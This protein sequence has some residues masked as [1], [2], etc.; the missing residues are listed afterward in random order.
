[1]L[2]LI[3]FLLILA[4]AGLIPWIARRR[5]QFVVHTAVSLSG[6]S[7]LIW[8]VTRTQLPITMSLNNWV[9]SG[10]LAN[11]EWQV[12]TLNWQVTFAILL[13]LMA[14][15]LSKLDV[16]L[17]E[18]RPLPYLFLQT[19][20]SLLAIW[21]N[22][23]PTMIVG[24]TLLMLPWLVAVW[25]QA[26]GD[27]TRLLRYMAMIITALVFLWYAVAISPIS[28]NWQ[29]QAFATG[30]IAAVVIAAAILVGIWPFYVWRLRLTAV[31]NSTAIMTFVLP[32]AIGG[33]I[34]ARL[35]EAT[36]PGINLQLLVTLLALFGILQSMRLAW[37]HLQSPRH[38][39]L[40]VLFAQ[41][42]LVILT[43]IWANGAAVVA[44]LRV[45]ILVGGILFLAAEERPSR[46]RFWTFLAPIVAIASLAALPLTA[47]FV[48]RAALYSAWIENGRFLLAIILAFLTV[49]LI[50]AVYIR[51]W[52]P[53]SPQI[54]PLEGEEADNGLP[55]SSLLTLNEI[56]RD[57]GVVLLA[58]GLFT[59]LGIGWGAVHW[60]AWILILLTLIA[61]LI[62]PRF[63]G[64]A[65][66]IQSLFQQAFSFGDRLPSEQVNG[67]ARDV[68]TA[69][70][71]AARILEGEGGLVWL[72]ILAVLFFLLS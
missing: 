44:E 70:R 55:P 8:I 26:E 11:V 7:L 14:I 3:P 53:P 31:P 12:D 48:G 51:F 6:I 30:G 68:G 38:I 62:L 37:A 21:S 23:L 46:E 15:C 27:N 40:A 61:G 45:L 58:F 54:S 63:M 49:P 67:L 71:D 43:G 42:Q 47:G 29:V 25:Q 9:D 18:L 52:Q 5:A 2:A 19:A 41:A 34:F 35:A 1:M 60:L 28:D 56:G 13:L 33:I 17:A 10:F 64:E 36:Q 39:A 4:G 65:Q 57:G 66:R 59:I 72:F 22:N 69:V 32:T 50:T 24:L 20:V 16:P